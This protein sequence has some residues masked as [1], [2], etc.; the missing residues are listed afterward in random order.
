MGSKQFRD[1]A[2]LEYRLVMKRH[3]LYIKVMAVIFYLVITSCVKDILYN[4]PHPFMGAL[5]V[6]ADW[7]AASS[8]ASIPKEYV[9]LTDNHKQ[10][11]TEKTNV[12]NQLLSKGEHSLV[13]VNIPEDISLNGKIASVNIGTDGYLSA[14]PGYLFAF[15]KNIYVNAD[16]TLHITAPLK[17]L[18]RRLDIQLTATEG[19]YTRVQKATA[20]LS[21]IASTIDIET[22]N[23]SKPAQARNVFSKNEKEFTLFFHLL[24][25]IQEQSQILTVDI[26]FTDESTL[27]VKSDLTEFLKEYNNGTQ[28][29]TLKGSLSLPVEANIAGAGVINWN[30]IFKGNIDAY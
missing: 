2:C 16:D 14:S 8:D 15:T 28:P 18:T 6:T 5:E 30:E 22:E 24:G 13:I 20:T 4:T 19:D 10:V 21:G 29:L 23:R 12:F 9:I 25:V 27:C 7:S 17:Q 11:V 1:I 3:P 26:L